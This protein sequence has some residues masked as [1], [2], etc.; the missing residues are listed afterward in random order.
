MTFMHAGLYLREGVEGEEGGGGGGEKATEKF[1]LILLYYQMQ[2][3]MGGR[4]KVIVV[5]FQQKTGRDFEK[6]WGGGKGERIP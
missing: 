2:V 5:M 6:R 4:C 1:T 3:G